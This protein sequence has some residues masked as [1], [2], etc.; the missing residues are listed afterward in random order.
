MAVKE[1]LLAQGLTEEEANVI[2]SNPKYAGIY[3]KAAKDAEEGKTALLKAQET[4]EALEKWNQEQVTPYVQRA[5]ARV[6]KLEGELA[7]RNAHMKSLKDL[8]Y[9]I[10]DSYL[11]TSV[12]PPKPAE[13]AAPGKDYDSMIHQGQLAQMELLD[14]QGEVQELTGKRPSIKAEYESMKS[15]ARPGENF[16]QYVTRKYDLETLRTNREKEA[17]QKKLDSYA[18]EKIAA[19]EAEWKTKYGSNPETVVPRSS[20]FDTVVAER[21]ENGRDDKGQPLWATK[22]GRDELTRRRLEKYSGT[23]Q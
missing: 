20:R 14:I 16:R 1:Y 13:A 22:T 12:T 9:E 6:A 19:K 18:A 3:E 17:E 15:N 10:P 4:K 23:M 21:K 5:D 8:G 2:V 11:E 7:A